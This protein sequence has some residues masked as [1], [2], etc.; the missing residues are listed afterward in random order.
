[1]IQPRKTNLAA[2]LIITEMNLGFSFIGDNAELI[3]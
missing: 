1:M 3:S 2:K